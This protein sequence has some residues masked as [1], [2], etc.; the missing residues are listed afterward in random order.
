M[1][2]GAV[3]E[4]LREAARLVGRGLDTDA[5]RAIQSAQDALDAAKAVHLAALSQSRGYEAEGASSATGWA[6]LQL[7]LS[8]RDAAALSRSAATLARLPQVAE[9]AMNGQIRA[10]H[11]NV[12]GYGLRHVGEQHLVPM[13]EPLLRVATTCEPGELFRV[14]KALREAV[15]PDELDDAWAKGM[16]KADIQVNPVPEGYHVNGFLPVHGGAKFRAVLDSLSAPVDADDT[17]SGAERRVDAIDQLCDQI[18]DAGLPSDN[19]VRPHLGVRA[20]AETVHAAATR[21]RGTTSEPMA[22][23]DLDTFGPIGPAL[24]AMIGCTA[25]VTPIL[26]QQMPDFSVDRVLNVGRTHRLATG[27]QRLAV[28]DRQDGRCAAPG[29]R[30]THLQVH[31]VIWWSHGGPT[32]LDN[33]V[34]LCS[35]CHHLVHRELLIIRALG[36][37]R[38]DF[39][40]R[41]DRAIIAEQRRRRDVHREALRIHHLDIA[42]RRR[43]AQRVRSA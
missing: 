27:R 19:G 24:L 43:R 42:I 23:A 20:D 36:D 18:L 12:F 4:T 34:G 17:R 10:A 6:R 21:Q 37:G 8:A 30:N 5:L 40:D 35:R 13:M 22:P 3:V 14:V 41:D 1:D 25:D 15:Y 2:H 9:A 38:F 32:D 39:T 31:H 28:L 29:C 33:L 7:R 26:T 16:D 11:V